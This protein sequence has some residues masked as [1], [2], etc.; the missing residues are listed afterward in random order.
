MTDNVG[1]GYNNKT[2]IFRAPVPGVY[3]FSL[4]IMSPGKSQDAH[5][6]LLKNGNEFNRAYCGSDA[7]NWGNVGSITTFTHQEKGDEVYVR[8]FSRP[9]SNL[10]GNSWT[11]FSAGLI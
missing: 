6:Q 1:G 8:A 5:L 11:S 4:T 10:Y 9:V 2:G 3:L 7:S